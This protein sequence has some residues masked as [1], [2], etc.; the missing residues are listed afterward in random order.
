MLIEFKSVYDVPMHKEILFSLLEEREP[1]Q[2]VTHVIM[3]RFIDEH[4]K[5]VESRPD[6]FWNFVLANSSIAGSIYIT[7]HDEVGIF[8]FRKYQGKGIGK[9]A[10]AMLLHGNKGKKLLANINPQNKRSIKL[11]ESFG[12]KQISDKQWEKQHEAT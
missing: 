5:F 9:L 4:C 12:F 1:Y 10:L 11:F 7:K 2:S 8:L 3:P 6:T